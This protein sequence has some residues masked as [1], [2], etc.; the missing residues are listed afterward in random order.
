M[1]RSSRVSVFF[2]G[3]AALIPLPA[4]ACPSTSTKAAEF[5][6]QMGSPTQTSQAFGT[7]SYVTSEYRKR[8]PYWDGHVLRAFVATDPIK[9]LTLIF[10]GQVAPYIPAFSSSLRGAMCG[11][12]ECTWDYEYVQRAKAPAGSLAKARMMWQMDEASPTKVDG[13]RAFATLYCDYN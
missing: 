11:K 7:V 9:T 4:F 3:W 6:Q 8:L 5:L 13:V 2:A 12:E 1:R 10:D